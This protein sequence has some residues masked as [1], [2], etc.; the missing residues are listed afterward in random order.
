VK[1]ILVFILF[2]S[3][4]NGFRDETDNRLFIRDLYKFQSIGLLG[5]QHM[6][7]SGQLHK[8]ISRYPDKQEGVLAGVP[9]FV[10]DSLH[11]KVTQATHINVHWACFIRLLNTTLVILAE[12]VDPIHDPHS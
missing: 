5:E 2:I 3:R 10:I 6:V 11:E 9:R 12:T 7:V 8:N 4:P 1:P